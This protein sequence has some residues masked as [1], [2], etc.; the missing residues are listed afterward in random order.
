M[1]WVSHIFIPCDE[2]TVE[3]SL[4]TKGTR[5]GNDTQWNMQKDYLEPAENLV[6]DLVPSEI[7]CFANS[8]GRIRRTDV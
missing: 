3:V 4:I 5:Y 7:A 1:L 8:P 2:S 6:T